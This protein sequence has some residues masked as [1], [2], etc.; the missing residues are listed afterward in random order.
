MAT[1]VLAIFLLAYVDLRREQARAL[2][3][4]T[5]EQTALA[6]AFARGIDVQLAGVARD[7]RAIADLGAGAHT[8][9]ALARA[10]RDN[11]LYR[12]IELVGADGELHETP[13]REDRRH[14]DSPDLANAL[15]S[16][17]ATLRS[18]AGRIAISP[19]LP[20][21]PGEH[22]RV[23]A[24]GGQGGGAALIVDT[25]ALFASAGM[26]AQPA[27]A[28]MCWL[29]LDDEGRW[30]K[31]GGGR[32]V[33]QPNAGSAPSEIQA[34][35]RKMRDAQDGAHLIDRE[36]ASSL[37]LG[38]RTAVAGFARIAVPDH[39][40]WSIAVVTS[41]MRMRDRARVAAFRLGAATALASLLVALFGLV[42]TRQQR[43]EHALAEALRLSE[44]TSALRERSEKIVEA[45]PLGVLTLG[46]DL[47]VT[48][49]NPY[50]TERG[51]RASVPLGDA[52]PRLTAGELASLE[53]L[54][55]S[56][57]AGGAPT[58]HLAL[59]LH[60][61]APGI[62]ELREVDAYAIPLAR[63]LPDADCFVVLH[64]RTELRILERNLV[65]AEKLATIGTLAA[66]VAHEVGTPLGIIS[67]R[68]E[69][70]QARL[71]RGEDDLSRKAVSSILSQ[72]DK[73]STT[74]RQL[75]DFAR[76]R[77]IEATPV[78]PTQALTNA[79]SLLEHRFRHGKVKL[80]VD[81]PPTVPAALA[82]PGQLEQVLVNLLLNACDA[83]P[84]GGEVVARATVRA[85][86][87][88]AADGTDR[89]ERVCF[90]VVDTGTGIAE[91]HLPLVLDPFFTTKK[92]GQG[93]GLGLTIAADIVKN[94][95]GTLELKSVLGHGT[96]V[97][98]FLPRATKE[99][100][101]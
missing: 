37:G 54:V 75:L 5:A 15:A 67:G 101:A 14:A 2:E 28:P 11:P 34:L 51:A 33:W 9:A 47:H 17:V 36:A 63:P 3:D 84:A 12:R 62:D 26:E 30:V 65:R 86:S 13:V 29:V 46:R 44:A 22:L 68:A 55:L 92:R 100:H 72:V 88:E 73:V 70:I 61:G 19:P 78:T 7:A 45:I 10:L 95:G 60:M 89:A 90:E 43:R 79:A 74:I 59:R 76:T 23:F 69:Q 49:A 24:T 97:R 83:C 1:A 96:T 57:R 18:G 21:Q 50:L 48:S 20:A 94:H 98:F 6:R 32:S 87:Q 27:S 56:A 85:I 80:T 81:A 25:S 53:A 82:D 39:R 66:G 42:V 41:A 52:L 64:D 38:R 77:P 93:T 35:L 58:R 31:I 71:A 4:F 40:P 16:T 8:G 91:E 99:A